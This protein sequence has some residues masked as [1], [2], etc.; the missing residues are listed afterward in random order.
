VLVVTGAEET[1]LADAG[2]VWREWA[3]AVMAT[4]VPGGHFVPEESP[5][6]LLDLLVPFLSA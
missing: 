5:A 6:A 2:D 3:A 1:Q 4:T